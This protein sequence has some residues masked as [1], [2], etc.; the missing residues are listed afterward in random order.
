MQ[1]QNLQTNGQWNCNKAV[2]E[3]TTQQSITLLQ[4]KWRIYNPKD[5]EHV[6]MQLKSLAPNGEGHCNKAIE[7]LTKPK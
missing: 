3:L 2:D 4:G 7:E 1:L 5:K 6:T